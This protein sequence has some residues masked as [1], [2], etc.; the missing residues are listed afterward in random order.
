MRAAALTN[1]ELSEPRLPL[2]TRLAVLHEHDVVLSVCSQWQCPSPL[3]VKTSSSQSPGSCTC[4]PARCT[5]SIAAKIMVAMIPPICC[6]VKNGV[7]TIASSPQ[8]ASFG[9]LSETL[10]ALPKRHPRRG[11]RVQ[12]EC[13]HPCGRRAVGS[14][15][16]SVS[17]S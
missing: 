4:S 11:Y 16:A 2:R 3:L 9:A 6:A 12:W 7:H 15:A 1:G 17:V 8:A 10:S 5:D 14:E 13:S